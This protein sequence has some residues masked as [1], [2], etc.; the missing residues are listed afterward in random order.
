[1]YKV[2]VVVFAGR[3]KGW[4]GYVRERGVWLMRKDCVCVYI[5]IYVWLTIETAVHPIVLCCTLWRDGEF[6]VNN[7]P[8]LTSGQ[9][10]HLFF[11][12]THDEISSMLHLTIHKKKSC[13]NGF[14]T[15]IIKLVC[16][17]GTSF[18]IGV[19]CVRMINIL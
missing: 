14:N 7:R 5:Y 1:M 8:I 17:I 10:V 19:N 15:Y 12:V 6:D 16:V 4:I 2:G 9:V 13:H 11:D 3:V 18:T